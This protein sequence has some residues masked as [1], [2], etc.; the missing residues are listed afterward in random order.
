MTTN[1]MRKMTI[2]QQDKAHLRY[3][4]KTP[5]NKDIWYMVNGKWPELNHPYV[6]KHVI[7]DWKIKAS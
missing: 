1:Q 2:R 4:L 3:P 6:W 7:L 5:Y